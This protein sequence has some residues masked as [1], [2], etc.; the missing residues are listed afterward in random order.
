MAQPPVWPDVLTMFA[1]AATRT[2]TV[3]LGTS[4]A[5]TYPR[6][7]LVLA[8]QVL[9]LYDLAPGRLRLGIGP[10][11]RFIIEDIYGLQQ[12][13]PLAHLREYLE[14][15]R[16]ALWEGKINHHGHFYNIIATLPRTSQIPILISTLG[17]SAFQLAGQIADGALTW[18]C[19][20]PYLL[21][22]GIP[23]LRASAAAV[24]RSPPPLVA[25]VLVAVTEDQHAVLAA[26]HQMLD[27]YAKIP[28]YANMFSNAGFSLTSDQAVPEAL[29]DSLV[30]SGNESIVAARFAELLAAG[31]DE[32]MV[33][34]V[35]TTGAGDD[36][37]ALLMHLIGRL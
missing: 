12:R 15:L 26:G 22:T 18:V 17:K 36:E 9:S 29:V 2:S 20:V 21:D 6:H 19:P 30:I 11:H 3:C 10:S 24:G 16:A 14:V 33:S 27:F 31:L 25:H 1:A 23:A 13:T 35:P 34:L 32:L 8:Q 7:P 4:I 5:P 28:F 37:Q